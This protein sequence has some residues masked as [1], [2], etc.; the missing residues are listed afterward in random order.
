MYRIIFYRFT[1]HMTKWNESKNSHVDEKMKQWSEESIKS[2]TV[3][4][5]ETVSDV[6]PKTV[7][8]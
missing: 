8:W 3:G 2:S 4:I 6:K 1:V 7:S 5:Y